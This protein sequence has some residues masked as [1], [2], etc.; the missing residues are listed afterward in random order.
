[1]IFDDVSAHLIVKVFGLVHQH[2]RGENFGFNPRPDKRL[3]IHAVVLD[4][5]QHGKRRG[6]ENADPAQHLHAEKRTQQKIQSHCHTAGQRGADEL[7]ERQPEENRFRIIANLFVNTSLQSLH[8][9]HFM[10]DSVGHLDGA[11]QHQHIKDQLCNI[12]PNHADGG[13]V[14]VDFR[15]RGRE[16]RKD[17]AGEDDD[18]AF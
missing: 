15:R 11:D 5:A 16:Q 14:G 8:P 6:G 1:M 13:S 3:G 2:L 4:K 7:S 18:R 17:D 9:Q 10:Y 12:A